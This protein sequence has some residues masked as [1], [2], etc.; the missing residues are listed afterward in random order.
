MKLLDVVALVEDFPQHS[1]F[2]GQVGTVVETLSPNV[3]EVEFSDDQGQAYAV[4]PLPE[5]QLL[6]L[7]YHRLTEAA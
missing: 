2:R 3:F 1:L 5:E 6:V 7:H 4:V